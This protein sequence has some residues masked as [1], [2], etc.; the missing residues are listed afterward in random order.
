MHLWSC[1]WTLLW[2]FD[3]KEN[4]FVGNHNNKKVHV[5][6][7]LPAR[8]IQDFHINYVEYW[9][10]SPGP[11]KYC[12][13]TNFGRVALKHKR[14]WIL[15]LIFCGKS[16]GYKFTGLDIIDHKGHERLTQ[17]LQKLESIT[18]SICSPDFNVHKGEHI[19]G[20][21]A[22]WQISFSD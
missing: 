21:R 13:H 7:F 9:K 20:S 11:I 1:E 3:P 2:F 16:Y 17:I 18:I 14:G 22:S 6:M 12:P 10:D 8:S 5:W 15:C 4:K 19:A